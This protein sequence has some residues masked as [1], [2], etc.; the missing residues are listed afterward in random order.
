[1]FEKYPLVKLY[2]NK[3][4]NH[5]FEKYK[6]SDFNPQINNLGDKINKLNI[7]SEFKEALKLLHCTQFKIS[8][9]RE[10]LILYNYNFLWEDDRIILHNSIT[11]FVSP[12]NSKK[13]FENINLN[14]DIVPIEI[15]SSEDSLTISIEDE[16]D[17]KTEKDNNN[18]YLKQFDVKSN[19]F[20]F[21]NNNFNCVLNLNRFFSENIYL[22][23]NGNIFV[24][25]T[26]TYYDSIKNKSLTEQM[27]IFSKSGEI[28]LKKE[29]KFLFDPIK[30]NDN[31]MLVISK[32]REFL[33][34]DISKGIIIEQNKLSAI[35]FKKIETFN[36][37]VKMR[38]NIENIDYDKINIIVQEE[39]SNLYNS[40]QKISSNNPININL[41]QNYESK[42]I[43]EIENPFNS[44]FKK[45]KFFNNFI[46]TYD[47]KRN[48]Y[49]LNLDTYDILNTFTINSPI[50]EFYLVGD[51]LVISTYE[52]E[53][54]VRTHFLLF[55]NYSNGNQLYKYKLESNNNIQIYRINENKI[56]ITTNYKNNISNKK[57]NFNLIEIKNKNIEIKE[58]INFESIIP[59]LN[60][61]QDIIEIKN[62]LNYSIIKE[63]GIKGKYYEFNQEIYLKL[64]ND[65]S[66]Y[67]QTLEIC[68]VLNGYYYVWNY[69]IFKNKKF[70]LLKI[71]SE[72]NLVSEVD[73]S[74]YINI[75]R[76]DTAQINLIGNYFVAKYN[77]KEINEF[78]VFIF[79]GDFN[80]VYYKK[81]NKKVSEIQI[82]N[83]L[84]FISNKN[85]EIY[86]LSNED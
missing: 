20:I 74:N 16:I 13:Y 36:N 45:I 27:Y 10:Y 67:V 3:Y 55:L 70:R 7:S 23:D 71:N 1:M 48:F 9:N 68:P 60:I 14:I 58:N 86:N 22:F 82:R 4:T 79:D 83:N 39:L 65:N 69:D 31:N 26:P 49:I 56:Y 81:T 54:K 29:I 24:I 80:L 72:L 38:I 84:L 19:C 35:E 66:I 32:S 43:S 44:N 77:K 15:N 53:N 12:F 63:K 18:S 57:L 46:F 64:N 61:N 52:L 42:K 11:E 85:I 50:P 73:F 2:F 25:D 41:N 59:N 5:L 28:I 33:L 62:K 30:I 78:H 34:F 17:L 40:I 21:E 8:N 6:S 75:D 47:D 51:V 37:I 76:E